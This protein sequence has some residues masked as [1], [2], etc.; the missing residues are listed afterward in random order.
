[1][2]WGP[3]RFRAGRWSFPKV[4]VLAGGLCAFLAA[5]AAAQELR[6]WKDSTGKFQ[7]RAKMVSVSAGKVT[8]EQ[9]DGSNLEI[10]LKK[11]SPADQKYVADQQKAAA[12]NPFKPKAAD[13]PFK[14]R[15]AV[16]G[17][18]P[19]MTSAARKDTSS[20]RTGPTCRPSPRRRPAP[21]G[22][23]RSPR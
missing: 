16:T 15:S 5:V 3:L 20:N 13:N 21:N 23:S 19:A 7:I 11:L 12:D 17:A 6:T 1:M 18:G 22:K 4:L 2:R 8:L 9:E 10:D 14:P